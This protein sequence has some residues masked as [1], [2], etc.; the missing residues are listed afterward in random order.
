MFYR[1]LTSDLVWTVVPKN[2]SSTMSSLTQKQGWQRITK[3]ELVPKHCHIFCLIQNPWNR[4]CKGMAENAYIVNER[5]FEQVRKGG[6]YK[7]SFMNSHLLPIS[8]QYPDAM[9]YMQYVAMDHPDHPVTDLLNDMF[10]RHNSTTRLLAKD[11]KHV[12]NSKKKAYQTEVKKWLTESYPY[13]KQVDHFNAED[14][15]NWRAALRSLDPQVEQQTWF[16]K[17]LKRMTGSE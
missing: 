1:D 13:R 3:F 17:L 7:M 8:A 15:Q 9:P 2:M 5:S 11:N 14:F 6:Y 10:E 16:Q 4:F 12:S